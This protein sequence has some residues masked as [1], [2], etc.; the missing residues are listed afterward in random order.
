MRYAL[1]CLLFL[2]VPAQAQEVQ[3]GVG[4]LC[5]KPEQAEQIALDKSAIEKVNAEERSCGIL[6]VAYIKG[7]TVKSFPV[8]DGT[9]SVV[10]ITVVGIRTP[11]GF[12]QG[13]PIVQFTIFLSRDVGA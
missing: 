12:L 5:D 13:E 4:L 3:Y 6:H 1:A 2:I 10:E 9:A 8:K 11:V 7:K